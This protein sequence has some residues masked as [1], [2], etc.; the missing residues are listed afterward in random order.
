MA[1]YD[2]NRVEGEGI[3]GEHSGFNCSSSL[4]KI[5]WKHTL[6]QTKYFPTANYSKT[7]NLAI[8]ESKPL[9]CMPRNNWY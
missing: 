3:S 2:I 5:H 6:V 7:N 4:Y 8:L 9:F 1:F